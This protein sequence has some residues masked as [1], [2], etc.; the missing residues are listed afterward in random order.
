MRKIIPLRSDWHENFGFRSEITSPFFKEPSLQIHFIPQG[1]NLTDTCCTRYFESFDISTHCFRPPLRKII[2]QRSDWHN[3]CGFKSEIISLY[4]KEPFLQT[5]SI[6]QGAV[7]DTF[8]TA[9]YGPF[10]ISTH[11]FRPPVRNIMSLRSHWH[12]IVGLG[13]K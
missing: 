6:P 13:L 3:I 9:Y 10:N 5:H 4:F 2:S 12:K 11:C 1:D 8:Y 7:T